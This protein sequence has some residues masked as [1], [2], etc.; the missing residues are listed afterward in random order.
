MERQRNSRRDHEIY[1]QAFSHHLIYSNPIQTYPDQKK[2][3]NISDDNSILS[4]YEMVNPLSLNTGDNNIAE[5]YFV[6][7]F[8]QTDDNRSIT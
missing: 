4:M 6:Y 1:L 8:L 5:S 2:I 3:E 7:P